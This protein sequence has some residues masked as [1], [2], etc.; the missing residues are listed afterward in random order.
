MTQAIDIYARVSRKGDKELRSTGGQVEACRDVLED[1]GLPVGEEFVDDGKSAWDPDVERQDWDRLMAKLESGVSG[2]VIV[3]DLERLSRQPPEG[4]RLIKAAERGVLVLDSDGVFDLTSASG[5]KGF[6]DAMNAAAYYS[7]RLSDRVRRGKLRK[8]KRGE[9]DG[10]GGSKRRPFGFEPDGVTVRESEA[11]ILRDMASRFL[12]DESQD[13]IVADLNARGILTT[14]GQPWR[15]TGLREVL[16]R[17]RNRGNLVCNGVIVARLPARPATHTRDCPAACADP[18]HVIP[19]EPII[20]SK[21]FDRVLARYAA[22]RPGR[23]Y[24][25]TYLCSGLA[26]CG[27]CLHRLSTRPV[28]KM[29][30]YDDG[31]VRRQ[32]WCKKYAQPGAPA[33]GCGAVHVDQRGLD[34]A[35]RELAIAILSD[36]EHAAAI[37]AA[38]ARRDEEESGL[39]ALIATDEATALEISDR[40]GRGEITLARYDAI[41]GPLDR[42]LA[43]L[44]AAKERLDEPAPVRVPVEPGV[45]WAAR[46]DAAEPAERRTLLAKALQGRV[47]VVGKPD[48]D[49]RASVARRVTV[50]KPSR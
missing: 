32:Y 27:V 23:P 29:R 36:P 50:T 8:A 11:A 6:R 31:E 3:F 21:T 48:P 10:N 30:A 26:V 22:R 5:K 35:A 39:A 41:M 28:P 42:R 34:A 18:E 13:S 25:R 24:T 37:G 2:G 12:A 19:G 38:A 4:E 33:G 40:L 17:E 49:D 14:S 7:D 15:V 46:W 1:R 43:G 45:A 16:C 47:M 9:V 20:D 44:R